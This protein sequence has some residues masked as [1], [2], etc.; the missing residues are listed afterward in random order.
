ME[1]NLENECIREGKKICA[2][3][4]L[5]N[6][7]AVLLSTKVNK[8]LWQLAD[9]TFCEI[10]GSEHE[11]SFHDYYFVPPI[12]GPVGSSDEVLGFA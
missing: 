7:V 10:R 12:G 5:R 8:F 11:D 2:W 9:D 3:K 4:L 1:E 6:G